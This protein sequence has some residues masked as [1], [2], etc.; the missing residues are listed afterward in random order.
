MEIFSKSII[1][2]IV[3]LLSILISS[4]AK[5]CPKYSCDTLDKPNQCTHVE[6]NSPYNKVTLSDNCAKDEFC[7][8]PKPQWG[9]LTHIPQDTTFTCKAKPNDKLNIKYPGEDC[10]KE[11]TCIHNDFG[12]VC[13]NGKC[14]GIDVG[15]PCSNTNQCLK[16]LFCDG[17]QKCVKQ[18]PFNSFC[19]N[20]T[21]CENKYL[22]HENMCS[23]KPYSAEIGTKV[24]ITGDLFGLAKCKFGWTDNLNKCTLLNQVTG[25]GEVIRC[26][27]GE[28]MYLQLY[29]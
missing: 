20:S 10:T 18:K 27:L 8:V 9:T 4:Q 19:Q 14:T 28:E 5:L 22:C 24:E 25:E 12:S 26:N 11:D 23:L 7:N 16:G 15:F 21:Q 2:L 3:T 6:L 13:Q 29:N 1:I 17:S